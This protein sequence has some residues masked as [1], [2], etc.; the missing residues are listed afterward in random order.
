M[1]VHFCVCLVPSFLLLVCMITFLFSSPQGLAARRS[2]LQFAALFDYEA[3]KV[4]CDLASPVSRL[5]QLLDMSPA[6]YVLV[7]GAEVPAPVWD[8]TKF[9]AGRLSHPHHLKF[10]EELILD[11]HPEKER[12]LE[13]MAGMRSQR[14]FNRFRGRFA[15][16]SYDCE[17]PPPRIFRNNFQDELTSTGLSPEAGAWTKILEDEETGAVVFVGGH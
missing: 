16:K 17:E 13:A 8:E 12:L 6:D 1:S 3:P 14:Y 7:A 10:W 4:R 5:A 2:L 11:G 9:R 15:G